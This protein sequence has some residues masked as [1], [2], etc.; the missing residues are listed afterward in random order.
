MS[1]CVHDNGE[2]CEVFSDKE[3][4]QPCLETPL[5]EEYKGIVR[6]KD[7]KYWNKIGYAVYCTRHMLNMDADDFCSRGE[8]RDDR[9][10][11]G[12]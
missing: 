10:S 6:C 8:R 5:C 1:N 11:D 7:C 9:N 3:V 2:Y 4:R 12:S